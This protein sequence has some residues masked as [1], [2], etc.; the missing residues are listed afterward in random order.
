MTTRTLL[1]CVT[2]LSGVL[3]A[4]LFLLPVPASAACADVSYDNDGGNAKQLPTP[5][6]PAG[7]PC[8][9][10]AKTGA[11]T[12]AAGAA[13]VTAAAAAAS[14]VRGRT[15]GPVAQPTP[16]YAKPLDTLG[17]A[18]GVETTVSRGMLDAGTKAS[19]RIKP[20]GWQGEAAGHTRGHLLAR[21][22]GGDGRSPANIV[23]MYDT[24]NNEVMEKLEERIYETVRDHGSVEYSATPVYRQPNDQVPAG[25]HIK[26]TGPGL[27]IDQTI[28]NKR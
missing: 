3:F 1:R 23:I 5:K 11:G 25:V 12:V 26:A 18:T 4:F 13:A 10:Q 6:P 9:K 27:D 20:P 14:A 28:I 24:A 2:A 21:S 17:R 22:L 8:G 19:R 7:D 16:S 15:A